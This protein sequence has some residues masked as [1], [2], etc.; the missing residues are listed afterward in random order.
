MRAGA[1]YWGVV[2]ESNEGN[3]CTASASIVGVWAPAPDLA[4]T[5]VKNPP[6]ASSRGAT[7][8]AADTTKNRGDDEAPPSTVRYYLSWN[9]T[10][11]ASDLVLG[12][13]R[14]VPALAPGVESWGKITVTVPKKTPLGIYY[15]LAGADDLNMIQESI[16]EN[17]CR[18]ATIAIEIAPGRSN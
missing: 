6:T 1:D 10:R 16:E 15:L 14:S 17:N 18:V 2:E 5:Y 11:D 3:S 9:V 13:S 7:F 12:G 4:I 8:D